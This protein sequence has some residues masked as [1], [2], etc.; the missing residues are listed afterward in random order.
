MDTDQPYA[1][2]LL[3]VEDS[4]NEAFVIRRCLSGS[5][6]TRYDVV[7]AESLGNALCRLEN[8]QFDLIL[9]DLTLPDSV[10]LSTLEH[11]IAAASDVPTVVLTGHDDNG[12]GMACIAAGAQ[13]Y[14]CKGLMTPDSLRTTVSFALGRFRETKAKLLRM[15]VQSDHALSSNA[16]TSPVTQALAG[17]SP[18]RDREATAFS[19]L[20]ADYQKLL[21]FYME[22]LNNNT[23]TKPKAAMEVLTTQIG[24]LGATPR[25]M[26]DIHTASLDAIRNNVSKRFAYRV[27]TDSRLFALEMMGMLVDYYRTGFRRLFSERLDT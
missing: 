18:I 27:A 20:Q 21:L 11:I 24:D 12:I 13:D 10:G 19:K 26:M 6:D 2:R 16:A 4:R 15:M 23:R 1:D 14:L 5:A 22:H 25:D 3:L 9:L 8:L 17:A 7:V